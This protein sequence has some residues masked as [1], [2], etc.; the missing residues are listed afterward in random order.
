MQ[1]GPSYLS[2][3]PLLS[4]SAQ[5]PFAASPEGERCEVDG[6]HYQ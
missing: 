3:A 6:E 5:L 1:M 2:G 4:F